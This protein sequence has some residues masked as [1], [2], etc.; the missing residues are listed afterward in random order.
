MSPIPAFARAIATVSCAA[1]LW[2]W[3]TLSLEA[4]LRIA[5]SPIDASPAAIL[6]VAAVIAIALAGVGLFVVHW[7]FGRTQLAAASALTRLVT[8]RAQIAR[9]LRKGLLYV[10]A[11]VAVL[12]GIALGFY[13]YVFAISSTVA[14]IVQTAEHVD[15]LSVD[16]AGGATAW[17]LAF[18][19]MYLA[20]AIVLTA[21]MLTYHGA[22]REY[23][24]LARRRSVALY[25]R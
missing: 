12:A 18:G 6:S 9:A 7:L 17:A 15:E 4:I 8:R 11:T 19:R 10:G 1:F 24:R 3:L 14:L 5:G 13:L 20:I 2:V 25:D 21:A 16:T 23:E 22:R